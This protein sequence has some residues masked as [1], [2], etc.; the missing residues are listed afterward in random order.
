MQNKK[1]TVEKAKIKTNKLESLFKNQGTVHKEKIKTN[2]I[3]FKETKKSIGAKKLNIFLEHKKDLNPSPHLRKKSGKF[4][5]IVRFI[6][7]VVESEKKKIRVSGEV[8]LTSKN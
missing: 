3:L 6:L 8:W 5:K 4:K 2:V 7:D 1:N